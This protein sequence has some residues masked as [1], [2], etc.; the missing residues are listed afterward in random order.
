MYESS[1]TFHSAALLDHCRVIG[2]FPNCYRP[3][4]SCEGYV[5]TPVCP[6]GG[7]TWAGTPLGRY[8]PPAGTAPPCRRLLL[9]TVRILLE[10]ILVFTEFGGKNICHY[11]KGLERAIYCVRDQNTARVSARHTWETGSLNW[12]QFMLEWF[13]G[14]PEFNESSVPFKKNSITWW[15]YL[16]SITTE[17][18]TWKYVQTASGCIIKFKARIFS[19]RR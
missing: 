12:A 11:S 13:I 14:F 5:F 10:C 16:P 3:Q 19:V 4:Q 18:E 8:T 15:V 7:S 1:F 6:R 2:V 17:R 9:Q